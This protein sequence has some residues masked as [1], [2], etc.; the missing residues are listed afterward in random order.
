MHGCLK[1]EVLKESLRASQ[2]VGEE[3]QLMMSQKQEH[4][5]RSLIRWLG[6]SFL[7]A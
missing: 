1:V 7:V 4:D 6:S 5:K 2:L 3:Q